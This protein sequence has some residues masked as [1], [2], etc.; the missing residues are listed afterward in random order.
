MVPFFNCGLVRRHSVKSAQIYFSP[1]HLYEIVVPPRP[2][3]TTEPPGFPS[4]YSRGGDFSRDMALHLPRKA[5]FPGCSGS[6]RPVED[7]IS[8]I[9]VWCVG[10]GVGVCVGVGRARTPLWT[11]HP[12]HVRYLLHRVPCWIAFVRPLRALD[13]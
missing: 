12:L 10:V 11:P 9:L 1:L 7:R 5:H 3:N 13:G 6:Y 2:R 4:I 8:F